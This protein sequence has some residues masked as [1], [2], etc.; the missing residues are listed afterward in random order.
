VRGQLGLG[1]A[2]L[3]EVGGYSPAAVLDRRVNAHGVVVQLDQPCLDLPPLSLV[4]VLLQRPRDLDMAAGVLALADVRGGIV[5]AVRPLGE[6]D[7]PPVEVE[8]R[9]V[10]LAAPREIV[11]TRAPSPASPLSPMY[12]RPG[13][14]RA[15]NR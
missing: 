7:R 11:E 1:R 5:T 3:F 9:R 4:R 6:A 10:A 15:R 2:P 8:L 14:R 13:S 12:S